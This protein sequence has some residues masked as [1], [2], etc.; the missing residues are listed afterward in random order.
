MYEAIYPSADKF[1]SDDNELYL[2]SVADMQ[3]FPIKKKI[4]S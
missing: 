2:Y 4:S 3:D 1:N